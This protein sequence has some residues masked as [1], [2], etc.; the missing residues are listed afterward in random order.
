MRAKSISTSV[1]AASCIKRFWAKVEKAGPVP[2][3]APELGPCWIWTGSKNRQ[4]Y[5]HFGVNAHLI[6]AAHRFAYEL[7]I[8]P[9]ARHLDL[10]HLCK[11]RICV[12]PSH[13]EPVTHIEN[14]R[15]GSSPSA[16]NARA[17]TCKFGHPF[18]TYVT[19]DRPGGRRRCKVCAAAYQA[20]CYQKKSA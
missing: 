13:M 16:V 1:I 12:N 17:E 18:T 10:D 15:R 11:L 7:T 8:G 3:G 4:G 9:V 19:T 5:G 2:E 14:V 20:R 6:F